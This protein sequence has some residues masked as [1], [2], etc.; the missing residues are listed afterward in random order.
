MFI[1]YAALFVLSLARQHSAMPPGMS[2]EEHLKQMAKD[3]ALE[4]RGADAMGFD[5]GAATHHF[6]ILPTGGAIE[7]VVKEATDAGTL[8][9][10]R[11]HLRGIAD[12]FA[13]G[14]FA[15]PVATHAEVPPGARDMMRLTDAITYRYEDVPSG[16]RVAITTT[17]PRALAA[18]HEFLRYQ[19]T[20][21]KTGDAMK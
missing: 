19:I 17:H 5:Q 13:R 4:K 12:E 15:S 8:D 14:E 2:H 20:E 10:I 6:Q 21:H 1:I 16:G 7:V 11:R 18:V 9:A 3:E